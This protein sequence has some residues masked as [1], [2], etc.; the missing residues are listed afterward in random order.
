MFSDEFKTTSVP[1][2]LDFMIRHGLINPEKGTVRS[3][4][5]RDQYSNL[6]GHHCLVNTRIQ[7]QIEWI[8][9]IQ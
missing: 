4:L 8:F 1:V 9:N 7:C 6:L 3:T 5:Q 2:V